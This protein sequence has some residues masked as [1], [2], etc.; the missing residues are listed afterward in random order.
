MYMENLYRCIEKSHIHFL[1]V[2]A[3]NEMSDLTPNEKIYFCLNTAT[4]CT[5]VS[6]I[7]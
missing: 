7:W 1:T 2:Y 6:A 4:T 5:V 3:K